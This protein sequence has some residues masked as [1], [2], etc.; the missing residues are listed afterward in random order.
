MRLEE[1]E[2]LRSGECELCCGGGSAGLGGGG[3]ARALVGPRMAE[4]FLLRL[5]SCGPFEDGRPPLFM[6]MAGLGA[7]VGWIP[8][9][10]LLWVL[11]RGWRLAV[12]GCSILFGC[13]FGWGEARGL[14]G[15]R[16]AARFLL[17]LGL[18]GPF[19]D[20]W[21]FWLGASWRGDDTGGAG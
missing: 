14:V 19:E 5:G 2:R 15:P 8:E 20:G 1:C 17:L 4:G 18:R 21:Y 12:R 7:G 3:G 16:M 11:L 6:G 13:L 10:P 9:R